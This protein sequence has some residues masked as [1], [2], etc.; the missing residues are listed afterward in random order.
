MEKI[1][2]S[3]P[4]RLVYG[5]MIL[6]LIISFECCKGD[7]NKDVGKDISKSGFVSSAAVN[8]GML[9]VLGDPGFSSFWINTQLWNCWIVGSSSVLRTLYAAS[10]S[11]RTISYPH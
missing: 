8:V 10:H 6:A 4:Q 3:A 2:G 1:V 7:K 5:V 9:I 11:D